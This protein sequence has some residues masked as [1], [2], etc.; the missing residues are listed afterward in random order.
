MKHGCPRPDSPARAGDKAVSSGRFCA[1]VWSDVLL[2]V[3]G[4]TVTPGTAAVPDSEVSI[5]PSPLL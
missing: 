1:Q 4:S 3:P 2:W 5:P